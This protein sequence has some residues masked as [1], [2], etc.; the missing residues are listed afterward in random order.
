MT[1]R[2]ISG[3]NWLVRISKLRMCICQPPQIRCLEK[4][5]VVFQLHTS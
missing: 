5:N 1:L 2:L 4:E 3:H